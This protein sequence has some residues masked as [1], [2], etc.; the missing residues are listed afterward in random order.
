MGEPTDDK[1]DRQI[2]IERRQFSYFIHIPERRS[3]FEEAKKPIPTILVDNLAEF[4]KALR[5]VLEQ[6]R[7]IEVV[8]E[9]EDTFSIR[10]IVKEG[11]V[12]VVVLNIN[13]SELKG[14]LNIKRIKNIGPGVQVI[15]VSSQSDIRYLQACFRAG[16][17]GYI[18]SEYA[19]DELTDAI[20]NVAD[21]K[22][23]VCN[24][25]TS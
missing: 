2:E 11:V 12:T 4:R 23:Y 10:D 1:K 9:A 18:L 7:D 19:Y 13:M 6:H 14:I 16:A 17:S 24:D 25:L 20:R 22:I 8:A 15:V 5:S 3:G 21:G